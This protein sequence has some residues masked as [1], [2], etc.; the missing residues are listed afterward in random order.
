MKQPI[1][2]LVSSGKQVARKLHPANLTEHRR[3]RIV[4][5]RFA[6]EYGLVYF[7]YVDQRDDEHRLVR[8]LTLSPSHR[9]N[10][11]CIGTSG[12]YDVVALERSGTIHFP[13]KP[14]RRHRWLIMQFDLHATV[15]VPHL[16]I[17]LHTH[18]ETFYAHLFTQF[19]TLAKAPLGVFSSYDPA[20]LERYAVY[21][22]P[23]HALEARQL[24]TPEIAT[25]I[26]KHF[27]TLTMELYQGCLYLYAEQRPTMPLLAAMLQN[28]VW[29][30]KAFDVAAG[31]LASPQR[32]TAES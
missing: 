20:F 30:A 5:S 4:M 21:V 6:E 3:H 10:H 11:Y 25:V 19:S 13:G 15:D 1:K 23:A 27:G 17:G 22:A 7:G 12:G 2:K 29:L 8:G 32:P 16:F 9:D 24:L 26:T 28:G 31:R 14:S 18:S